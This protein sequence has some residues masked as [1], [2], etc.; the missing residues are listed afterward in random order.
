MPFT[1]LNCLEAIRFR[2][3]VWGVGAFPQGGLHYTP[4]SHYTLAIPHYTLTIPHC[5]YTLEL[6]GI[7]DKLLHFHSYACLFSE[8][9]V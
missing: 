3:R 1:L 5:T 2:V 7:D 6:F 8:L 9:E 4:Q